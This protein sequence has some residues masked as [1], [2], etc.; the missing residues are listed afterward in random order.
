MVL[1]LSC[2]PP[3]SVGFLVYKCRAPFKTEF[4]DGNFDI[5]LLYLA[6]GM[7]CGS[8]SMA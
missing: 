2:C 3:Q 4:L 5:F 1:V 7:L 8:I 6:K